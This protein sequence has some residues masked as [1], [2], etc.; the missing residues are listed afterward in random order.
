MCGE[1]FSTTLTPVR[2]PDVE[3]SLDDIRVVTRFA[4]ACASS[5]LTTF[6]EVAPGDDRP[7]RAL[8]AALA[9]AGGGPRTQDLRTTAVAAHRAA[10]QVDDDRAHHAAIAAGDAAA[11]AYLHPLADATQVRHILGAAAHAALARPDERADEPLALADDHLRDVL[12]RYPRTSP[13]ST[14]LTRLAHHLDGRLRA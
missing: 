4:V 8:A 14:E 9:F 5:V 7:R 13:G 10:K 12:Q 2:T 6:Q 11:S 3:L 1:I